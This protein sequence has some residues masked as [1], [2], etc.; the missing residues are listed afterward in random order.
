M[1]GQYTFAL[2][3]MV[4]AHV[5]HDRED[6][7]SSFYILTVKCVTRLHFRD[8]DQ[9]G[10]D[11]SWATPNDCLLQRLGFSAGE[12]YDYFNIHKRLTCI[13][14]HFLSGHGSYSNA[15]FFFSKKGFTVPRRPGRRISIM[16]WL[17]RASHKH[18]DYIST[19]S[20]LSTKREGYVLAQ[21]KTRW[22]ECRAHVWILISMVARQWVSCVCVE[23]RKWI[24]SSVILINVRVL[25]S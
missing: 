15:F 10:S 6:T 3:T 17:V 20:R 11:H 13:A 25:I 2:V 18:L 22:K 16:R 12:S 24:C 8:I 5:F 14:R 4:G 7:P 23:S 9:A 21:G 1:Y 19:C